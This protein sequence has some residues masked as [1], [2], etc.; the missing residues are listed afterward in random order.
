MRPLSD[1]GQARKTRQRAYGDS[2]RGI[3]AATEQQQGRVCLGEA[4]PPPP[5]NLG[6]LDFETMRANLHVIF[7]I[8]FA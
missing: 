5:Q 6:A 1:S 4:T 2:A 3:L 7:K 8:A